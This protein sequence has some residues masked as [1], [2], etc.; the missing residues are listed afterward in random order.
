MYYSLKD[1]ICETLGYRN[2]LELL[3]E[4]DSDIVYLTLQVINALCE[5]CS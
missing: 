5:E 2:L 4:K 3:K 1:F